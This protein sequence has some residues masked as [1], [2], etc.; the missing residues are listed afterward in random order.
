MQNADITPA[1]IEQ[2]KKEHGK[3][4]VAKADGKTAYYRKPTRKDLS[5]AMTLKKQPLDMDEAL[6][7]GCFLGG[8]PLHEDL[9]YLLGMDRLVDHM[10][11]VKKIEVGEA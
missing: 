2:W 3:V 1:L 6:L 5:Y 7:R 8:E 9:D 11:T 4:F 10:L